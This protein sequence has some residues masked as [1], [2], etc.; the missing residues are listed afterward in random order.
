MTH[1]T[2]RRVTVSDLHVYLFAELCLLFGSSDEYLGRLR[3]LKKASARHGKSSLALPCP[4]M[5]CHVI[6]WQ[7]ESWLARGPCRRAR[8]IL[9]ITGP[10][11]SHRRGRHRST[12]FH[13]L[14]TSCYTRHSEPMKASDYV[15]IPVQSNDF[16]KIPEGDPVRSGIMEAPTEIRP[17]AAEELGTVERHINFDWA[18]PGKHRNR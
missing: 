2:L 6:R 8:A 3:S 5:T 12:R 9:S 7:D 10:R 4:A 1:T 15:G 16:W 14:F 11:A 17:I 18:A 13:V